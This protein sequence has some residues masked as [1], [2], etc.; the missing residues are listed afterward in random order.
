MMEP[1]IAFTKWIDPFD[2]KK[3]TSGEPDEYTAEEQ[4]HLD[5]LRQNAE[6]DGDGRD[7]RYIYGPFGIIPINE[8]TKPSSLYNLWNYSTNF[9]ITPDV[10]DILKDCEGVEVLKVWTRYRG[11]IGIGKMFDANTV[12]ENI[13]SKIRKMFYAKP[14]NYLYGESAAI[15]SLNKILSVFEHHTIIKVENGCLIPIAA[16]TKQELDDITKQITGK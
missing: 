5:L 7:A 16:E 11:W 15:Y 4:E 10:L 14:E 2:K 6:L 1:K 13:R 12:F 3:E 8:H 9:D